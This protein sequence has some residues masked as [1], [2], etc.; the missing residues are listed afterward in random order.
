MQCLFLCASLVN[1]KQSD[2]AFMQK[3]SLAL[4]SLFVGVL[5]LFSS[6]KFNLNASAEAYSAD[7]LLQRLESAV[8]QGKDSIQVSY[9][10]DKIWLREHLPTDL[11]ALLGQNYICS[12]LVS[13]VL[14]DYNEQNNKTDVLF[15][16]KYYDETPRPLVD[17]YSKDDMLRALVKR[18]NNHMG[19]V[20]L[21]LNGF[22]CSEAEFF[23]VLDTAELNSAFIPSEANQVFY[24]AFDKTGDKQIVRMWLQFSSTQ[25][26]LEQKQT[27]LK[28]AVE[29]TAQKI[30]EEELQDEEE[31][32][33]AVFN[34]VLQ[35]TV[36]DEQ[37]A[38][39]TVN[40]RLGAEDYINRSAYGALVKGGTICNGYVRAFSALCNALDLPCW[41]VS[42]TVEGVRHSWN[43]VEIDGVRL[44]I[45]CT[46]E[47]T[48][49]YGTVGKTYFLFDEKAMQ[50][51]GYVLDDS[52]LIPASIQSV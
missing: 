36:Y 40:Q 7:T 13:K 48:A 51:M 11:S 19:T 28:T 15:S 41:A 2:G 46:R 18:W 17:V 3:K 6:C 14:V 9:K 26:E 12:N 42:G 52:F 50:S 27:G 8:Y 1:I 33:G 44:Y 4:F 21:V 5:L 16:I 37:L 35:A 34:A 30:A 32:Y 38:Y 31:Q 10:E 49:P 45:D 39:F 29:N 22:E 20:T 47:D 23:S 25:Q 43:M 24:E